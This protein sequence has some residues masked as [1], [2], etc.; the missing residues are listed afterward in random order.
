MQF[1]RLISPISGLFRKS[2]ALEESLERP[3]VIGGFGVEEQFPN[4]FNVYGFGPGPSDGEILVGAGNP[5]TQEGAVLIGRKGA[6]S[7]EIVSLPEET[8]HLSQFLRL[9][10][11]RYLAGGMTLIGRAALLLGSADARSWKPVAMDLHPYSSITAMVRLSDGSILVSMGQMITQGK[12]KPVL[13]RS[14][15]QG[16]TWEKQE[17]KLPVTLFQSFYLTHGGTL[18]AGTQGDKDPRMYA[19]TDA[20]HTWTELP[21]F[22]GYKTYKMMHVHVLN[23]G[24]ANERLWV[25]LWGYKTDIADRVVRVYELAGESWKELPLIDDSHFV[26]AFWPARDGSFYV[27]SEKGRVYRSIDEGRTWQRKA[28]FST[29]VGAQ[30]FYEDDEGTLWIGKDSVSSLDSGLWRTEG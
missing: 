4:E 26:F 25:V 14:K 28:T 21:L 10:N 23:E 12:T 7:W 1:Q 9:P 15:D 27:G 5:A 3:R 20:G 24:Q 22:P 6:K 30:A 16:E 2:S 17:L 8:A 13:F 18:Y 29:N 19:S 11:G